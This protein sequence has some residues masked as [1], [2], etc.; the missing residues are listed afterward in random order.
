MAESVKAGD[1]RS[2]ARKSAWVRIPLHA[3]AGRITVSTP[4]CGPGD[5]GSTPL[6]RWEFFAERLLVAIPG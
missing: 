6:L 5:G 4:G 3:S 2:L 1:L